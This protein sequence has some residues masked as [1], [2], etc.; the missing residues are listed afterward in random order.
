MIVGLKHLANRDAWRFGCPEGTW[1][2]RLDDKAWGKSLNLILYFTDEA[3]GDQCW[4]SVFS[5][6]GYRARDDGD[7]FRDAALGDVFELTTKKTK[8][9]NPDL[10]SARKITS[11]AAET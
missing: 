2:G 8:S 7:S 4:F 3:T 6:N 5:R 10:T 1:T 11:G 9:G